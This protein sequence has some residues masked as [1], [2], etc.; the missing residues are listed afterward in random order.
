MITGMHLMPMYR[1]LARLKIEEL[2]VNNIITT[3]D[4]G[5]KQAN[6]IYKEI[7]DTIKLIDS[8]WHSLGLTK[9]AVVDI[10]DDLPMGADDDYYSQVERGEVPTKAQREAMQKKGGKR[11]KLVRRKK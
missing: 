4:T 5:R 2:G 7:R 8:L 1:T 9:F 3:S 11:R 10:P 6:P